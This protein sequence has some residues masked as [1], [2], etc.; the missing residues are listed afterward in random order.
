[1][2]MISEKDRKSLPSGPHGL[3]HLGR[4]PLGNPVITGYGSNLRPLS[5]SFDLLASTAMDSRLHFCQSHTIARLPC[6]SCGCY[7]A[8]GAHVSTRRLSQDNHQ[9]RE[10]WKE[11]GSHPPVFKSYCEVPSDYASAW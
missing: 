8:D 3:R 6:F 2:G 7:L 5:P 11:T 9:R 4:S 10:A 1:M